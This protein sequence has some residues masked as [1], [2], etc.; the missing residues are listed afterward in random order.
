MPIF[1]AQKHRAAIGDVAIDPVFRDGRL[2][3][4]R[5]R[6]GL[7][8]RFRRPICLWRRQRTQI[9]QRHDAIDERQTQE[10]DIV[11]ARIAQPVVRGQ[12]GQRPRAIRRG[13]RLADVIPNQDIHG[14]PK[15]VQEVDH[16]KRGTG[17]RDDVVS[18]A[19]K[20]LVVDDVHGKRGIQQQRHADAAEAEQDPPVAL[21]QICHEQQQQRR[22]QVPLVHV[23]PKR[24]HHR[25][26]A[27]GGQ[28][29]RARAARLGAGRRQG[30]ALPR[31]RQLLASPA[32]CVHV[33]YGAQRYRQNDTGRAPNPVGDA[34]HLRVRR[35]PVEPE[36]GREIKRLDRRII[37]R[38]YRCKILA[39][40]PPEVLRPTERQRQY[41]QHGQRGQH[42]QHR[43]HEA[44]FPI[45]SRKHL[46][47]KRHRKQ[48]PEH[49]RL[50]F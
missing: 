43:A 12:F 19:A 31:G 24:K 46:R 10:Q 3:G 2:L 34:E 40:Q 39:N 33:Q 42:G 36:Q 14:D 35:L 9:G 7:A 16:F 41:K 38:S 25:K 50:R 44:F 28:V 4:E 21:I 8:R 45:R 6:D 27:G 11:L 48:R 18:C 32:H 13:Q 15:Q 17:E 22:E 49:Q 47:Q 20:R 37:V 29:Q 23:V 30:A 26:R 5:H 1:G